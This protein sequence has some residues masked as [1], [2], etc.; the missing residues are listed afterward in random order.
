MIVQ[1]YVLSSWRPATYCRRTISC[2]LSRNR[3][4]HCPQLLE[5][6]MWEASDLRY[7]RLEERCRPV[8]KLLVIWP[9]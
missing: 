2:Q 6:D 1:V 5:I 8:T 7:R 9:L 3:Q 4:L